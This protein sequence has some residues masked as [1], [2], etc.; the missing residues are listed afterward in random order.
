MKTA[1]DALQPLL[2]DWEKEQLGRVQAAW[3]HWRNLRYSFVD[4]EPGS[5]SESH[6]EANYCLANTTAE[7]ADEL[8]AMQRPALLGPGR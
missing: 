5:G 6:S 2:T 1:L 3:R 7:R 8:E 4:S